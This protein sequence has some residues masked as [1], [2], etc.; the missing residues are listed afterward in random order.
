MLAYMGASTVLDETI[1]VQSIG[2]EYEMNNDGSVDLL[3]YVGTDNE[4]VLPDFYMIDGTNYLVRLNEGENFVIPKIVTHI[5]NKDIAAI[6]HS[7]TPIVEKG[8]MNYE[9]IGGILVR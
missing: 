6:N 1:I 3:K 8:N 5:S 4:M 9:A 2:W 7:V